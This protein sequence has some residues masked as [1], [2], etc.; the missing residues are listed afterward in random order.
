MSEIEERLTALERKNAALQERFD[1]YMGFFM[2]VLTSHLEE[3][4]I[5]A[6]REHIE[7]RIIVARKSMQLGLLQDLQDI[8]HTLDAARAA[9][10]P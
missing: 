10:S 8:L 4:D 6:L 1:L 9:P 3:R 7:R 2:G 5:Q